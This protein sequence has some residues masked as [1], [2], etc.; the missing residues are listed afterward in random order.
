[1]DLGDGVTNKPTYSSTKVGSKMKI[2]LVNLL[3]EYRDCFVLDY[4]ENPRLSR[5]IV[6]HRLPIQQGKGMV[7]QHPQRFSLEITLKIKQDIE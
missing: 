4:G 6:K 7:K 1:M 3:K 5:S 2:Q